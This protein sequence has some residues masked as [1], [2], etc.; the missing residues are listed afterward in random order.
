M[1]EHLK[2]L[3]PFIFLWGESLVL[4][5]QSMATAII[6]LYY[7]YLNTK[8]TTCQ[9]CKRSSAFKLM[10][11]LINFVERRARDGF[12]QVFQSFTAPTFA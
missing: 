3:N 8:L 4:S 11:H 6:E 1:V 10:A 12:H 5:K 7:L 9:W 2:Q